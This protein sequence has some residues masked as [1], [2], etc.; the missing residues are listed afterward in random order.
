MPQWVA[1][2]CGK[3]SLITAGSLNVFMF[4]RPG[5]IYRFDMFS[6]NRIHFF[7]RD[8]LKYILNIMVQHRA[9][10]P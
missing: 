1:S 3:T 5:P 10:R 8:F 4:G 9:L 2:M 7:L 6:S